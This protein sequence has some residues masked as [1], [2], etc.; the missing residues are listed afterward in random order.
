MKN[1]QCFMIKVYSSKDKKSK[2]RVYHLTNKKSKLPYINLL[3]FTSETR[4]EF[5]A[6]VKE[7]NKNNIFNKPKDFCQQQKHF[8]GSMSN[9]HGNLIYLKVTIFSNYF[10]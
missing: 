3:I 1:W 10:I 9:N 5:H 6:I 7:S 4:F 2:N 8:F